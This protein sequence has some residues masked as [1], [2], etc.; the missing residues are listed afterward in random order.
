MSSPGKVYVTIDTL[1]LA[2][3]DPRQRNAIVA[4]L[5]AEL[6]RHFAQPEH[7]AGL[8]S[9]RS[10]ASL[11]LPPFTLAAGATP[12]Q[13]AAQSSQRLIH[14]LTGVSTAGTSSR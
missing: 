3:F 7:L 12:R 1:A 11:R 13:V 10:V 8:T 14:G 6:S 9:T 4:A 5:Q 2:G